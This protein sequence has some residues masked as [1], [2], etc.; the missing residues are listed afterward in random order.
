M[1]MIKMSELIAFFHKSK[2]ME[3]PLDPEIKTLFLDFLDEN[4]G[5]LKNG[6]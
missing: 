1:E 3:Y 5:E 6:N 4:D 2:K